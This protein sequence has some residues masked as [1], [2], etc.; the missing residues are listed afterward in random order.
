MNYLSLL[1]TKAA[2]DAR[3]KH[4]ED[5]PGIPSRETIQAIPEITKPKTWELG[6]H[7]HHAKKRGLHLDLRLGDPDT[8]HAHSWALTS[9]WP[10]PGGSVWAIQQPTHTVKYMDFKGTIPFGYGAGEVKLKDRGKTEVVKATDDHVSFNIYRGKGPEE[11][12]L[13]RMKDKTWKLF[14]RTLTKDKLPDF[15]DRPDYKAVDPDHANI[16]NSDYL[17]S[18]KIDDAHNL[19]VFPKDKP[20]RVVSYRATDRPSGVIEHT[21]KVD[22]VFGVITPKDLAGT[23]LRG[24]LVAT[25]PKTDRPIQASRLGGLLNSNVWKSREDQKEYGKLRPVIYDVVKHDGKE[26]SSAPY[27]DKLEVLE[28]VHKALPQFELAPMAESTEEKAKLLAAI[29]KKEHA[30]TEEG[31]VMWHMHK[32]NQSPLKVKFAPEHDIYLRGTFSGGGKYT[33]KGAGGFTYSHEKEGPIVG[34]VGTGLSDKLREDLHKNPDRYIGLIA[35]VD[36]QDKYISGALRMPT[37]KGWHLDKNDQRRLDKIV[38]G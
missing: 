23:V 16:M 24:G 33:D 25:N 21:H 34:R 37:F 5:A 20:I 35:K 7:E 38:L 4:E 30:S 18:A 17:M 14:N 13:H 29:Q 1:L 28:K 11:Y 3:S 6:V 27:K 31:V 19:F 8:G 22:D 10:E 36:A 26:M 2:A 15:P 12:T 32:A 9:T